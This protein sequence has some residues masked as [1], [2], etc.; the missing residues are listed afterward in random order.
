MGPVPTIEVLL[1]EHSAWPKGIPA[2]ARTALAATSEQ[3]I[4]LPTEAVTAPLIA[5]LIARL[6][7]GLLKLDRQIK[8]LDKQLTERSG[9]H[10]QAD[11]ISSIPGSGPILGAPSC[12]PTPAGT[13]KRSDPPAGWPPT[14]AWPPVPRDPGRIKNSRP[15]P[16]TSANEPERSTPRR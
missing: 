1:R 16:Y 2:M 3:T 14:S 9:A 7:T 11:E 5:R 8:D 6:A 13:C 4:A 10:R 12:S 15:A